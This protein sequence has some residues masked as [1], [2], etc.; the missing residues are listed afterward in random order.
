MSDF[1]DFL[2]RKYASVAIGEFKPGTFAQMQ[3][4]YESAIGTFD[5]G[6]QGAYLL[7]E[8]GTDRGVSVI[9]W[10]GEDVMGD[11]QTYEYKAILQQMT[12]LF[13][14]S[15]TVTTYELVEEILPKQSRPNPSETP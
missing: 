4:L 10:D 6:F 5:E 9:F 15:P 13:A 11:E 12:P 14:S 8:P 7:R 2:K 3:K 1:Q